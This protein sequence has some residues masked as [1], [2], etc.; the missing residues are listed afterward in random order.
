MIIRSHVGLSKPVVKPAGLEEGNKIDEEVIVKQSV[1]KTNNNKK[2]KT[3]ARPVVEEVA[4]EKSEI[5][6]LKP[7]L[8]EDI[9]D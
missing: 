7:W 1:N 6:D 8:E 9:D 2:K 4:V 5:E 3:T